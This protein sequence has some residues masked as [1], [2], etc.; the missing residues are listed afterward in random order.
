[1]SESAVLVWSVI[2]LAVSI[3]AFCMA[4]SLWRLMKRFR[5]QYYEPKRFV[6]EQEIHDRL[7][8]LWAVI[9]VLVLY[10]FAVPLLIFLFGIA[11]IPGSVKIVAGLF[12]G[13]LA[14]GVAFWSVISQNSD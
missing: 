6:M 11:D 13:C 8:S 4:A 2:S 3:S 12:A 9:L 1:M 10:L 5:Q 14:I 7:N